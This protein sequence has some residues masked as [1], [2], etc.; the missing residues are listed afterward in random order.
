VPLPTKL[1]EYRISEWGA[2]EPSLSA[3][4]R[5]AV[6]RTLSAMSPFSSKEALSSLI[7]PEDYLRGKFQRS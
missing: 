2:A 1:E 6:L 3:P 7:K 5:R 4:I